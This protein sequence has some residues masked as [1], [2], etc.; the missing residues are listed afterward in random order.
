MNGGELSFFSG[1]LV[2]DVQLQL[3]VETFS[4]TQIYSSKGYKCLHG[5]WHPLLEFYQATAIGTHS[6]GPSFIRS[7]RVMQ[8]ITPHL[9]KRWLQLTT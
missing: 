4:L 8:R 6:V 3:N 2:V 5:A 1:H 9:T 7:K